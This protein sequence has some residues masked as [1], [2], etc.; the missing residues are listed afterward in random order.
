MR[1]LRTLAGIALLAAGLAGCSG[2]SHHSAVGVH[3]TIDTIGG[4]AP[5][6]PRPIPGAQFRLLGDHTSVAVRADRRGR[7]GVALAPGT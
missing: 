1:I 2:G 7:F 5:G 3:G 4:M 6:A